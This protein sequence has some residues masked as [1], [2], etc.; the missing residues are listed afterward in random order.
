MRACT[1]NVLYAKKG[2][3]ITVYMFSGK[4]V[5]YWSDISYIR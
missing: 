4:C 5:T 1:V 3:G 2:F